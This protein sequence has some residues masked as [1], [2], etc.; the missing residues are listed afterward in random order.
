M[1]SSKSELN[2]VDCGQWSED[3][4][5]TSN[6]FADTPDALNLYGKVRKIVLPSRESELNM[7]DCGQWSEDSTINS[8]TFPDASDGFNSEGKV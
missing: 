5:V 8:N 3:S 2:M 6:T 7:V 4:T 1:P